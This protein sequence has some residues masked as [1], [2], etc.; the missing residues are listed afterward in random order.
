MRKYIKPLLIVILLGSLFLSSYAKGVSNDI[1][2]EVI[3]LHIL[4]NSNT[5]DDQFTKMVVKK[6]ILDN[7]E[8]IF[9]G[10]T[11]DEARQ[12]IIE[13]KGFIKALC[14]GE[15]RKLGLNYKA[16]VSLKKT[17]FN[18]REYGEFSL[19]AGRYESLTI[20]LGKGVGNNWWCV[21][22]PPLCTSEA[23]KVQTEEIM[24]SYNVD[25]KTIKVITE[26]ETNYKFRIAEAYGKLFS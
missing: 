6:A 9:V 15:I 24:L 20:S 17:H 21:M 7:S 23:T 18:L 14:E 19:P 13:N 22:F 4:A 3:R 5:F 26:G 2:G 11:I 8:K 25:K 12:N 10:N 16:D 1:S